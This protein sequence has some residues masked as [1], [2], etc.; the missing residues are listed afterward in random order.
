MDFLEA[1]KGSLGPT[2]NIETATIAAQMPMPV[3]PQIAL[4]LIHRIEATHLN[5]AFGETEGQ[6]GVIGPLPRLQIERTSAQHI[7]DRFEGPRWFKL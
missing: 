2:S 3:P 1:Q 4:K 5:Q 6:R 7:V